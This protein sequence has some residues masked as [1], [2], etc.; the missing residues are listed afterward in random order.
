LRPLARLRKEIGALKSNSTGKL[1][2]DYPIE[3]QPLATAINEL[4]DVREKDLTAARRRAVDLARGLRAPLAALSAGSRRAREAGA[5]NAAEGLDRAIAS[6][7]AAVNTELA[8]S[9]VGTVRH[10]AR[11]FKTAARFA[12]ERV[13]G[14]VEHKDADVAQLFE[15]DVPEDLFVPVAPEDLTEL[16]DA[17][18]EN[19]LR[20]AKARV[21]VSGTVSDNAASLVIE[22]DGPSL[23]PYHA[24]QVSSKR[25][26]LDEAAASTNLSTARELVEA[27]RGQLTLGAATLG[28]LRVQIDWPTPN[29]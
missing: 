26:S 11:H 22:D 4:I 7:A 10:A 6:A 8:S 17:I 19:A 14:V 1:S 27:T 5:A 24:A 28:G 21:K 18:I 13:I 23:G 20:F 2:A 12:V 29:R 16:L 25:G 9:R 15:V 3:I